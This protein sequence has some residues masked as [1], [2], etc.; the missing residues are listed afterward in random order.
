MIYKIEN[1]QLSV[2]ISSFGAELQ[3]IIHNSRE[4][5]W[6]GNGEYWKDRAPVLFPVV[7]RQKDGVIDVDGKTYPMTIHGF[8]KHR[9]FSLFKKT[10][11][12]L[13][14]ELCADDE[15]KKLYPFD[16]KFRVSYALSDSKIINTFE[17]INTDNREI[18]FN[19][20]AHPGFAISEDIGDWELIF[21]PSEK[22][23]SLTCTK[24]VFIDSV[25]RVD[26]PAN[27]GHVTL[28]RKLFEND[29]MIFDDLKCHKITLSRKSSPCGVTVE[30]DDF[31]E[32]GI[33]TLPDDGADFVCLEP[34]C[35]MGYTIGETSV[36]KDKRS[37]IK[38]AAGESCKK[39]I[40]IALF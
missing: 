35:G 39:K 2:S 14:L 5:L 37:I 4:Y 16:F 6:Q 28:S 31:P 21:D 18:Y 33:W 17:V 8:A 30:F 9:E 1:E 27:G 13:T 19:L 38:L 32:V 36:L 22:L 12:S 11:S 10:D 3:S 26:I 23:R 20:G 15:T 25:N 24:E 29:A 7:G 40:D 34:W